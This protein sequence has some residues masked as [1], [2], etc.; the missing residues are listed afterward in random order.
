MENSAKKIEAAANV[1]IVV[2]AVLLSAVLIKSY[3]AAPSKPGEATPPVQTQRTIQNGEII[4]LTGIDW[5][6]NGRTLLMALSTTCHF[7]TESG[8]FYRRISQKRGDTSLVALFPQE[9]GES[10]QYLRG[11]GIEVNEIR[12]AAFGDIGLRGTPTLI[13]V[14]ERGRVVNTW[15]GVLRPETENEVFSQLRSERAGM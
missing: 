5:Q 13:L 4:N 3:L 7:C 6:K 2:V 9:V 11:L 10:Q 8:P 12:Q 1:A 14:D 15:V